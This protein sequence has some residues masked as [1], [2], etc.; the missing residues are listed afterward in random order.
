MHAARILLTQSLARVAAA[1][2]ST[3]TVRGSQDIGRDI[4]QIVILLKVRDHSLAAIGE[5]Q[6]NGLRERGG[7]QD[8][9]DERH[10]GG[11]TSTRRT[12]GEILVFRLNLIL[13]AFNL[14]S[15]TWTVESTL[16]S[17]HLQRWYVR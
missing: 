16:L 10:I 11:L 7:R 5:I 17:S 15:E 6:L 12:F 9:L 4:L 8:S 3:C 2:K 13:G 1:G 14:H